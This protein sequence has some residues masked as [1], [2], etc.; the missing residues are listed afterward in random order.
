MII[1]MIFGN[2]NVDFCTILLPCCCNFSGHVDVFVVAETSFGNE[3][4]DDV[5]VA[6]IANIVVD[7]DAVWIVNVRVIVSDY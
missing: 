6:W 7:H 1:T 3:H 5:F 4:S 2:N